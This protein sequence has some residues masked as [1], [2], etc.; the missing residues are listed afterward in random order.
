MGENFKTQLSA[1]LLDNLCITVESTDIAL[2][3][4]QER[5]DT[6]QPHFCS[7]RYIIPPFNYKMFVHLLDNKVIEMKLGHIGD[8]PKEIRVAHNLEKMVFADAFGEATITYKKLVPT[9]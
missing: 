6:V 3:I 1:E 7:T 4:N 8:N 2:A 5:I 9:N